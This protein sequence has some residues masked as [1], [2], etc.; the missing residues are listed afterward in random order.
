MNIQQF[1]EKWPKE[2]IVDY[3]HD[4]DYLADH[5]GDG[6]EDE[7]LRDLYWLLVDL[8]PDCDP[9]KLPHAKAVGLASLSR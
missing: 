8:F 7:F 5:T 3:I 6:E 4:V 1:R 2:E 9:C